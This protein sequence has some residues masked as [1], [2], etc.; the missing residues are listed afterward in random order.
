MMIRGCIDAD[1]LQAQLERKKAGIANQRYI[2]WWNDC[3]MSVKSMVSAA[4]Q[5]TLPRHMDD[6]Y[7]LAETSGSAL[8]AALSSALREAGISLLKNIA[9]IVEQKWNR[10]SDE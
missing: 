1:S 10:R 8:R 2:E 4:L 3:M 5:L 6:G 9:R 7:I